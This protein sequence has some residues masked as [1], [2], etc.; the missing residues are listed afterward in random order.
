MKFQEFQFLW[1]IIRA[2]TLL[3]GVL[4][5]FFA[6]IEVI[7]AYNTLYQLNE[8]AGYAFLSVI[9]IIFIWLIIYVT[10]AIGAR[11]KVIKAP[12]IKNRLIATQR[13]LKTYSRYLA[14]YVRRLC[15]NDRLSDED[16]NE[17]IYG[18]EVFLKK[19]EGRIT[20]Q[21]RIGN[22]QQLESEYIEPLLM[23]LD[24]QAEREVQTCVRDIMLGVTLSPYRAID[25]FVVIYR[26][27][28]MTVNIIKIYN[29]RPQLTEQ[30]LIC[31]DVVS[32]VAAVNFINFGSRFTEQLM[33]SVPYIGS[34]V[35]DIAQGIGAGLLTSAAGHAA[36][37]R[38][39]AYRGWD[40]DDSMEMMASRIGKFF[41]DIHNIFKQ[42]V[43][44]AMRYR[45]A[46]LETW[47][48]LTSGVGVVFDKMGDIIKSFVRVPV[49]AGFRNRAF[50]NNNI[51]TSAY[52]RLNLIKVPFSYAW[53][54]IRFTNGRLATTA[55][56][57]KKRIGNMFR[58]SDEEER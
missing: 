1:K 56:G 46:S 42:D 35:D 38:C 54:G 7:R 49:S 12:R 29:S 36:I 45:V 43:L 5:S 30:L 48:K 20:E 2:I 19:N 14:R 47:E 25:L 44:P 33:S 23:K 52:K 9:G 11:P 22:I 55:G 24:E 3:S 10:K 40:R 6:V 32:I 34:I 16:L 13:E 21:E 50:S 8:F 26:N 53:R 41:R 17:L 28:I 15:E 37:H 57:M 27:A 39:R 18:L 31:K 58:R 51:N 4:L